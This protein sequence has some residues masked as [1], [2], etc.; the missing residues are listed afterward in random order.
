MFAIYTFSF[1]LAALIVIVSVKRLELKSGK[2]FFANVRER[3]DAVIS[4]HAETLKEDVPKTSKILLKSITFRVSDRLH[5]WSVHVLRDCERGITRIR[6]FI[7]GRRALKRKEIMSEF[8][9]QVTDHKN[10]LKKEQKQSN[11]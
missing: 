8:L 4:N 2:K 9:Q 1:S 10:G 7:Q 3:L 11:P 6:Y 5:T